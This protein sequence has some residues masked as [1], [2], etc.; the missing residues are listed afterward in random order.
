MSVKI[1]N[2]GRLIHDSGLVL[3]MRSNG[4]D[5]YTPL[6]LAQTAVPASVT[7][8]LVETTLASIVIPGGIMGANGALRITPLFSHTNNANVKSLVYRLG[9]TIAMSFGVA[10]FGTSHVQTTIR[11]RGNA[12]S[13]VLYQGSASFGLLAATTQAPAVNTAVDQI[14]TLTATLANAADTITLEG[15]TIEIL[16]AA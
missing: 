4:I 7:G 5:T 3:G 16:P 11:N 14:L 6:V 2:L 13:Q 1:D 12:A 9:G 15:Y 10:N 8:T